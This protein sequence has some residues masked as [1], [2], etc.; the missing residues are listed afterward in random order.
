MAV[1]ANDLLI[2]NG[3]VDAKLFPGLASTDLSVLI[4]GYILSGAQDPFVLVADPALKDRM[5]RLRALE[6]VFTAVYVRMSAEPV[7]VNVAEKGGHSY[8][9][10][11]LRNIKAIAMQYRAEF[12]SLIPAVTSGGSK[13]PLPGTVSSGIIVEF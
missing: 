13:G 7:T 3:P 5:T 11:Q 8:S 4:E 6:Y 1:V 10:E 2:P 12:E 9:T